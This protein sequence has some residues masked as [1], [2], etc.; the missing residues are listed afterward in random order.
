MKTTTLT[1]RAFVA[2]AAASLGA[3]ALPIARADSWPAKPLRIVVPFAAGV[4][5][6]V[7]SR[8]LA[9]PLSRSLGQPVMIDNRAGAAGIIGAE[10]AAKSPP[11]G[12]TLFMAVNSIVGINPHVYAKLPYDT[13][14]DFMPVTQVVRVPYVLVTGPGGFA[15]LQ[16]LVTRAKAQPGAVN[17]GSLGVGSGPHVVMEMF[18]NMAGIRLTHVPYRG[19]S[20]PDVMA[21]H[22]ALTFDPVTTAVPMVKAGKLKAL[23]VTSPRRSPALPGVPAIAEVLPGYDGDGWQGFYL[24]AGTPPAVGQRLNRKLVVIL[25]RPEVR[26][27]L[28]DLGLE[29]VG[30]SV[31]E[32][33]R[34]TR[35]DFDKW[36]RIAKANGIRAEG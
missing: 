32:F 26:A 1:R 15:S 25:Q 31:E 28:V 7:V 16:D 20:V 12:Y 21:G 30:N 22:M 13:F 10:A 4:S 9:E 35:A 17:Y 8:L 23:A 36:G 11:D 33:G 18:T 27:R 14:R 34:V 5:P 29:P 2:G 6:D 24:P 3:A 19:N